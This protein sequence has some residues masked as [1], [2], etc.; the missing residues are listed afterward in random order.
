MYLSDEKGMY[1]EITNKN[2]RAFANTWKLKCCYK[3]KSLT[4]LKKQSTIF[5]KSMKMNTQHGK[6]VEYSESNMKI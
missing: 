3:T 2:N 5:L 4:K 1:P 6:T